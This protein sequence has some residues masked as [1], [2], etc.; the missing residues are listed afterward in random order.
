MSLPEIKIELIKL[1]FTG[2]N[3]CVAVPFFQ[4]VATILLL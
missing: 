4:I 1:L 3:K 2:L